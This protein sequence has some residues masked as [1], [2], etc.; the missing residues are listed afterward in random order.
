MIKPYDYQE[1]F[2]NE[3][4][5]KTRS[6]SSENFILYDELVAQRLY[7]Q[8]FKKHE[9]SKLYD[10]LVEAQRFYDEYYKHRIF[11][12]IIFIRLTF[13][14]CIYFTQ[15]SVEYPSLLHDKACQIQRQIANE[16]EYAEY[17]ISNDSEKKEKRWRTLEKRW[18]IVGNVFL[19]L[20]LIFWLYFFI[21]YLI[22]FYLI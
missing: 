21:R 19:M 18:R 6:Y 11:K 15:W 3:K 17:E 22:L 14:E 13:F 7:D 20:L 10:E 4:D 1:V 12:S 2:E 8:P 5:T 16:T 9:S